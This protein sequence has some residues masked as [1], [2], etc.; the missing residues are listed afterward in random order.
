MQYYFKIFEAK[1][2]FSIVSFQDDIDYETYPK[3]LYK[4]PICGNIIAFSKHNFT[5]HASIKESVFSEEL[6]KKIQIHLDQVKQ[7]VPNS[8][9]DFYCP[10]CRK[11]TRVYYKAWAGGRYTAGYE[12]EFIIITW[13]NG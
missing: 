2:F 7:E 10:K 3:S 1:N 8:A 6:Q 5:K 11:E 9:I 4:C 13:N 12:I